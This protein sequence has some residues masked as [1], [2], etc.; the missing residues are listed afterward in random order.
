VNNGEAERKIAALAGM[1]SQ[2]ADR[3]AALQ[4]LLDEHKRHTRELFQNFQKLIT[5]AAD[6]LPNDGDM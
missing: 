4:T 6:G 5:G 3:E 2:L 1:L